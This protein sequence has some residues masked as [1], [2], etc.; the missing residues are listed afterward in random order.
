[1]FGATNS[2]RLALPVREGWPVSSVLRNGRGD[3]TRRPRPVIIA[4]LCI[5]VIVGAIGA[6]RWLTL[7]S[8]PRAPRAPQVDVATLAASSCA[9]AV[10]V[11][12]AG[13][14]WL[15][16]TSATPKDVSAV[17][18]SGGLAMVES[19][20][21]P[22][23]LDTPALVYPLNMHTGYDANDC[24]HWVASL[25]DRAGSVSGIVDYVFDPSHTRLR[26]STSGT[27]FPGDSRFGKAIPYV[28]LDQALALLRQQRG[29]SAPSKQAPMLVFFAL[30][31]G[32][33]GEGQPPDTTTS[34]V[35]TDGGT[36]ATDPMWRVVGSDGKVYLVGRSQKVY[37]ASEIP[38]A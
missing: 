8:T 1:M 27:I 15:S 20:L 35:W 12:P 21:G 11:E 30:K 3:R 28:T 7:G 17:M 5:V 32:W 31:R 24:P 29:V 25:H 9:R 2:R 33:A 36:V 37:L 18:E 6:L 22:A 38:M 16:I 34:H 26:F 23:T 10:A 14:A 19:R 4:L 13:V